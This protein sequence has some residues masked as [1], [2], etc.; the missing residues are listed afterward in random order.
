VG[1]KELEG[2]IACSE[3]RKINNN[4]SVFTMMIMAGLIT[5][6]M[7]SFAPSGNNN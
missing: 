2:K 1:I 5:H 4:M 3:S 7:S 6:L